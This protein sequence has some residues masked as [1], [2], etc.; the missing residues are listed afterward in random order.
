MRV[1]VCGSRNFT[2]KEKMERVLDEYRIT[3]ILQGDARGADRLS[4]D[5]GRARAIPVESFP[6]DWNSF[7]KGAGPIRNGQMLTIGQP[8]LV[9]AFWDGQSRGTKNM[10]DQ[11]TEA[12]VRVEVVDVS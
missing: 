12:G 1:L 10:I 11:A 9:I 5:Y 7:G 4:A 3:T 8:D 2:D 6:A